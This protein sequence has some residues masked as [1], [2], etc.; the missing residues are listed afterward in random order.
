V[1]AVY[2][3]NNG[4]LYIT[5]GSNTNGGIPGELSGDKLLKDNYFS[6]AVLV[7]N[8]GEPNFNGFITYDARDNGNPIT[9]FGPNGVEVF[10]SGFRNSYG[11]IMHSNGK[12]Y[13]TEN[14]PNTGF[15]EMATGC[16]RGQSIPDVFDNDELNLIVRGGY[17]GHPNHKRA[18]TDPRQCTWRGT[19]VAS[20]ST[21]T[22]PL[23]KLQSSTD[24]II[25]YDA[26]Y[27]E[28]EM[29][30]NLVVS[31]YLDGLYRI[32]L[33]PDGNSVIPSSIPAIELGGDNGLSVTLAPNGNLIDARFDDN[34]GYVYKPD[35]P[36]TTEIKIYS[37]FPR[38]GGL[39]GGSNL[40]VYGANFNG[41]NVR[42]F[43]GTTPCLNPIVNNVNTIIWCTIPASSNV[44]LKDVVVENSPG[45]RK[46]LSNAYRYITGTP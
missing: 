40:A 6:A 8:L 30:H 14:G 17:Y 36:S 16:G 23:M 43:M 33:S 32:I 24:G 41:S 37:V 4:E 10:A 2:F 27:F 42:V 11:I 39:P 25:E 45:N 22:A 28:G 3:G 20:T 26:N 19:D 31:K 7:A 21:Y 46:T 34:D 1:N 29:R 38:R 15:G 18:E 5:V 9:G 12:L 35:E 44:G 13:A